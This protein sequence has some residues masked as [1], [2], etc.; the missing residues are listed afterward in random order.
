MFIAS[1]LLIKTK[2]LC[3]NIEAFNILNAEILGSI[4]VSIPACHAGDRGSIP[5]RGEGI[6]FFFLFYLFLFNGLEAS[7][8]F[9][10][11]LKSENPFKEV[12]LGD[13]LH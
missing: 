12:Y 2:Q 13:T 6:F 4:V 10:L 9:V 11:V 3:L 5:R 1:G 7:L 8:H